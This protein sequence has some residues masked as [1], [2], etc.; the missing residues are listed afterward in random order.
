MPATPPVTIPRLFLTKVEHPDRL[1]RYKLG[2][3][4]FGFLLLRT[5]NVQ[6]IPRPVRVSLVRR[7]REKLWQVAC[8]EDASLIGYDQIGPDELALIKTLLAAADGITTG[9]ILEPDVREILEE[10]N[11]VRA[12]AL[13]NR[14]CDRAAGEEHERWQSFL[15]GTQ[16]LTVGRAHLS[17]NPVGTAH[18]LGLGFPHIF[19][20]QP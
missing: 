1:E 19:T 10:P 8:E 4:L 16:G 18:V 7:R 5:A 3:T 12:M 15:C 17:D 14:Y 11:Y 20:A 2:M 6:Q 13:A 9:L